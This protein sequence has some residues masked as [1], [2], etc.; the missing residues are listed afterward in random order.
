MGAARARQFLKWETWSIRDRLAKIGGGASREHRQH[1]PQ[2]VLAEVTVP[3]S[4]RCAETVP[5]LGVEGV[6]HTPGPWE[7]GRRVPELT[8][9]TER[10]S[11]SC[12]ALPGVIE[13]NQVGMNGWAI[14][15]R[16]PAS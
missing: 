3:G 5:V 9:S 10:V 7:D 13:A 11:S 12:R 14:T 16:P 2:I 6:E 1:P 15:A 4:E 8:P